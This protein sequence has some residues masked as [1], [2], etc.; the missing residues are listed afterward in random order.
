MVIYIVFALV[1]LAIGT[2]TGDKYMKRRIAQRQKVAIEEFS[3]AA[4]QVKTA[5]EKLPHEHRPSY[6]IMAALRAL[7]TK[8]GKEE[9][10]EH[11]CRLDPYSFTRVRDWKCECVYDAYRGEYNNGAHCRFSPEYMAMVNG[12]S[13]IAA[14]LGRREQAIKDREHEMVLA[15]MENDLRSVEEIT[16]ALRSER[17]LIDNVTKEICS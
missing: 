7:D 9:V 13:D 16:K 14:A 15:G 4:K 6:D 11:F 3:W 2:Y 8:Y 10:N 5:Y 17:D 12:I 1:M